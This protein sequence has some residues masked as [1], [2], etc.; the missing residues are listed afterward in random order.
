MDYKRVRN[1][2]EERHKRPKSTSP[3]EQKKPPN[4]PSRTSHNSAFEKIRTMYNA[5]TSTQLVSSSFSKCWHCK[6]WFKE[7]CRPE[8]PTWDNC[9]WKTRLT[10]IL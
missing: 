7:N 4:L 1:N 8:L 10:I 5:T 2:S 3:E 9:P 6:A